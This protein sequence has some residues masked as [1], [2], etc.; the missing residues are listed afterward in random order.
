[1]KH[2]PLVE[3]FSG[4]A[5]SERVGQALQELMDALLEPVEREVDGQHRDE[6]DDWEGQFAAVATKV[7]HDAYL[8]FQMVLVQRHA[9]LKARMFMDGLACGLATADPEACEDALKWS[10]FHAMDWLGEKYET[11]LQKSTNQFH[12]LADEGALEV[13]Q[14]LQMALQTYYRDVEYAAFRHGVVLG[15]GVGRQLTMLAD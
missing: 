11:K 2:N 1:M 10:N 9:E 13:V 3:L 7:T 6:L 14:S 5:P 4:L 15:Q 12:T 8:A